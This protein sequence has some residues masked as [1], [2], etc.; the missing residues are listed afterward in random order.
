MATGKILV[1]PG[2]WLVVAGRDQYG[3][4]GDRGDL[5]SV[6]DTEDEARASRATGGGRGYHPGVLSVVRAGDVRTPRGAEL[7]DQSLIDAAYSRRRSEL[8]QHRA[9]CAHRQAEPDDVRPFTGA[10]AR[11]E[12]R[13]AHG[14]VTV[15]V[16]CACGARR[17]KNRNGAHVE[18]SG[19]LTDLT[20]EDDAR[21]CAAALAEVRRANRAQGGAEARS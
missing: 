9:N 16:T 17:R 19:W 7:V 1:A 21:R 13:A 20:R 5:A 12:N 3:A 4:G 8:V 11:D 18:D 15:T 14:C 10:V 2:Q 6:H